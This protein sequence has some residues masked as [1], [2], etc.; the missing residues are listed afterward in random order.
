MKSKFEVRLITEADTAAVLDIYRPFVQHTII[1]FEYEVPTL[2]EFH[3]RIRSTIYDYPW[4]VCLCD[5]EIIG[6]A[7]ASKHRNRAAYQWSP[8]CSVYITNDLQG[9][10]VG[11]ILYETL[12]SILR[13]Q[14]HFN[15]FACIGLP[16][17]RS[18]AF[19][20]SLGFENIGIFKK[21]GCKLGAWHDTN[22][23]QL[24]LSKHIDY[25][26]IPHKME[27]IAMTETLQRILLA[28][29]EKANLITYNISESFSM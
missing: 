3:A 9:H 23:F 27:E 1:S 18:V 22:W 12:F 25:P 4:L 2:D 29:T 28:A 19:H 11:R 16:N 20:K 5:N 15:V 24:R 21:V 10:G 8:E 13:L 26:P 6:Y 14:G 17:D 7:Y